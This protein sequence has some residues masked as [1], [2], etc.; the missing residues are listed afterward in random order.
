MKEFYV[1]YDTGT[2]HEGAGHGLVDR[3]ETPDGSTR[4][5]WIA[6]A[7]AKNLDRSVAYFPKGTAFD[8][9]SQKIEN[10]AIVNQTAQEIS[11]KDKIRTALGRIQ[12]RDVE[13]FRMM[14]TIWEVGITKGLWANTDLS[15][16]MK[17]MAQDWKQD[18]ADLGY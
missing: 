10:D 14:L 3:S 12:G 16:E 1:V 15:S 6:R 9:E 17:Q 11:D 13:L 18:L 8:P 4:F 5:E 7:L 2:G